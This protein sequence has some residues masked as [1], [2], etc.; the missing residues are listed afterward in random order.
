MN[1]STLAGAPRIFLPGWGVGTGPLQKSLEKT[2]WRPMPL[3]GATGG[4]IPRTITAAR[5]C[6]LQDLPEVC[7]LGGW[8]LGGILAMACA[9][10]APKRILSLFL[11]ATT[12]SFISR[13]GWDIGRPPAELQAFMHTIKQEDEALFPRFIGSFC[14]GD[15]VPNAAEYVISNASPMPQAALEAGLAWLYEADLRRDAEKI[16]CPATILHGGNDPLVSPDA[17]R[18]LADRIPSSRLVILPGRAHALF[19]G[20]DAGFLQELLSS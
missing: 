14:R 9:I 3:P 8:S 20:D 6:L 2:S 5:D 10:A 7:H 15:S 18:W 13:K 11:M 16:S 1:Q 17:S 12:P 4:T 19:A